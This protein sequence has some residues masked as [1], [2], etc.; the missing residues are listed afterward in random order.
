[1]RPMLRCMSGTLPLSAGGN[2]GVGSNRP[3]AIVL[4][5]CKVWP[6]Y[7]TGRFYRH[8]VIRGGQVAGLAD[9]PGEASEIA[10]GA[11]F[12]L[13]LGSACIDTHIHAL[14]AAA[15]V[16]L[17]S[18]RGAS[19]LDEVLAALRERGRRGGAGEWTVSGR[20]WHES[21]LSEG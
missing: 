4:T 1:M 19:T 17:V 3:A 14:Q 16:R 18:V 21:Q 6:G 7:Q 15:D 13:N 11:A 8:V 20:N 2:R 5:A 12:R 9:T 10:G